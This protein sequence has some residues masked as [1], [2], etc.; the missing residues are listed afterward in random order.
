MWNVGY[1]RAWTL[2]HFQEKGVN[3]VRGA[4]AQIVLRPHVFTRKVYDKLSH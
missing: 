4:G 1:Y 3:V 2:L